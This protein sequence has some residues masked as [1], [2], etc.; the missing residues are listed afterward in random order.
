MIYTFDIPALIRRYVPV[1]FRHAVNLQFAYVLASWLSRIHTDFLSWR[2]LTILPEYRYNGLVHSLERMLND[3]YDII[4]RRIFIKVAFQEPVLYHIADGQPAVASHFGEGQLT[5][6]YHLDDG[7]LVEPYL[8]EFM[9]HVPADVPFTAD[10][11]FADVDVYRYAGRRPAIRVVAPGG[12]TV[13][14][15]YYQSEPAANQP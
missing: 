4:Q 3:R 8:F 1:W 10:Q 14:I 13:A 6:Y 9:I 7:A 15:I 5:G 11:M 2:Q 12:V